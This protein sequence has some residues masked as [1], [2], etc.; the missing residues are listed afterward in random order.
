M[1]QKELELFGKHVD[2]NKME[3]FIPT[4]VYC[5]FRLIKHSPFTELH[6]MVL[7]KGNF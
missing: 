4:D 7:K 1:R 5:G 3:M 2:L 6:I